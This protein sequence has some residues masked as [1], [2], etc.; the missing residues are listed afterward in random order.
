[1][2]GKHFLLNYIMGIGLLPVPFLFFE[3]T[4]T[5]FFALFV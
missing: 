4:E 3:H 5:T 2:Y 1:M